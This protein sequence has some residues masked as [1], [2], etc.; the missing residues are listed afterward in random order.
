MSSNVNLNVL[1][2]IQ[3]STNFFLVSIEKEVIKVDKKGNENIITIS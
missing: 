2:K 1:G 3:K